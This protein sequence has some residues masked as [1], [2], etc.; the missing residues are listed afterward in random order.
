MKTQ[1][2]LT[3]LSNPAVQNYTFQVPTTSLNHFPTTRLDYNLSQNHR[4]TGSFNYNHINSTPDTTNTRQASFPGFIAT[5]SQQ[6]TRWTTSEGLRSTI[7][8]SMVNEFRIGATG[9]ATLFS[10]EF[11]A[12]SFVPQAGYHLNINGACC[13]G[14]NALY[15]VDSFTGATAT[16]QA[17]EASTK[18]ID[19]TL[20]WVKGSHSF[21]F[22]TPSHRAICGST[23]SSWC[24]P[25]TSAS[26]PAIRRSHSS[27]RRTF[28]TRRPRISTMPADSTRCSSGRFK[29]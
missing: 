25:S 29:A 15:N 23:T 5:G 1:G 4:I 16:Y 2:S 27:T 17:R 22:G 7:G 20:T 10:P 24:R 13:T 28:P 12:D 11:N 21:A 14:S 6:S 3:D 19:D 8:Q 9:G 26:S 18:I